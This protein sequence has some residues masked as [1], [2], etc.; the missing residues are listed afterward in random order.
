MPETRP[1]Q[2]SIGSRRRP[3]KAHIPYRG[4]SLEV[5]RKTGVKVAHDPDSDG[6]ETY[7]HF[8]QQA[9]KI[10]PY[11]IKDSKK[12]KGISPDP[13]P[14]EEEGDSDMEIDSAYYFSP[15]HYIANSRQPS[16]PISRRTN[17][18]SRP[19]ARNSA[20]QFDDV[21]SPHTRSH[22]KSR[23]SN[24]SAGRS[25][26][27][28][29]VM[30]NDDDPI[31]ATT[32][33]TNGL[34]DMSLDIGFPD[35]LSISHRSFTELDRD[36]IE[37]DEMDGVVDE[38]PIPSP[39]RKKGNPPS[40]DDPPA[41]TQTPDAEEEI[42][43]LTNGNE[44]IGE[45]EEVQEDEEQEAVALKSRM[46]KGKEKPKEKGQARKKETHRE[47]VRRS[48][49]RPIRPLEWWRNEKYVYERPTHGTILVPHI[50]EIIR[51]P[52]EPKEP[53]GK[54]HKRKRGRSKTVQPADDPEEG[55]DDDTNAVVSVIDWKTKEPKDKRIICLAKD[56]KPHRAANSEWAYQR[57][58]GDDNFTASGHLTIPVHGRKPTKTTKDNTY[59]FYLI[60]GAINLKIHE[61]SSIL[62]TGAQFMVPRGNTYFI[63]NIGDREAKL[64]FAQARQEPTAENPESPRKPNALPRISSVAGLSKTPPA[65]KR[66]TAT[67]V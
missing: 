44:S 41:Q 52:E 25:R 33:G 48:Q 58:F 22:N 28:Q 61:T 16:S 13:E 1:R 46:D 42:E 30:V 59:T 45:Q 12:K 47:G 34:A 57:I 7:E 15:I 56:I 66:A 21:P 9:D 10:T 26:L 11:K 60:Q 29:R 37:D 62:C 2:S 43:D 49:R 54:H 23:H 6:F 20:N 53:L 32:H 38:L 63:E 3:P 50:K 64:F 27:S 67:G 8:A 31:S 4:D 5:T 39:K 24:I 40:S 36:A 35:D 18:M 55:W 14:Q 19:V 65:T 17:S 51:I